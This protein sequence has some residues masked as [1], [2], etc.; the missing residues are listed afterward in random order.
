MAP[1][2]PKTPAPVLAIAATAAYFYARQTDRPGIE[3]PGIAVAFI[4]LYW[5]VWRGYVFPMY[6]SELRHIPTVSG[7]PL[8]GQIVPVIFEECGL[9]QRRW[10]RKY[11]PIVRY[12]FPFG[13]ERLSIADDMAIRHLTVKNH[14]NF[15]KPV[16]AKLWMVRILG[17]GVLLAENDEHTTQRKALTPGFST[18]AIRTFTPIFWDKAIHMANLQRQQLEATGEGFISLEVLEWFNRCT[19]DIIGVAGFGYQIDS[20]QDPALPIRRAY[21]LVFNFDLGSRIL[22]GLQAFFP[23]SKHLPAKMNRD[24]EEARSIIMNEATTIINEKLAEAESTPNAKDVLALIAQEN[25]KLQDKGE[26]GLSFETMRD[27]IMTFLGAGHDT[28]ATGAAWAMHM[29][30][31]HSD[32]QDRLREEVRAHMPCLFD[33]DFVFDPETTPM[34]DPDQLPYLDNFCREVLR[35][36]PPIPM[37]V[38]ESVRDDVLE[39]YKIPKN[40]VVYMLANAINRMEWFWGEDADTFN[41]DRWEHLPESAVPNAFMTFLQGPRGC[42]GRKFAEVE[43]KVILCVLLSRWVFRRDYNT[44]HPED[45]KMWRL[46]LRPKEGISIL[47]VPLA[48]C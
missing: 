21:Q 9:P 16:R 46:V 33:P 12:F 29:L 44:P 2:T 35:Y 4:L 42:L 20:L 40:T 3:S 26:P 31:I 28:T 47:A 27:Q 1:I 17:E 24:M 36:I 23:K 6:F 37:T 38:R 14:H 45:W 30:S 18:S 41:P 34:P 32:M 5:I 19:L 10:H 25:I 7:F 22:H 39:G 43:M 13:C 11:G 48:G 15:P 8:W